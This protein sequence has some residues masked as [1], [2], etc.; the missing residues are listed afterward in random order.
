MLLWY[1]VCWILAQQDLARFLA[2]MAFIGIVSFEHVAEGLCF[3][4]QT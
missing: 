2:K 4:R 1:K 3:S